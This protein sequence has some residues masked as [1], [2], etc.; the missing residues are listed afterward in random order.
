MDRIF[1]MIV[2]QLT[3]MAMRKGRR[4]AMGAA[5]EMLSKRA[6]RKRKAPPTPETIEQAPAD[7][8]RRR[9]ADERPGDEILYPTDGLTEDMQPR[10]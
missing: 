10:R 9:Q 1:N 6:P 5:Q 8:P 4:A 2:R 7:R 3:R